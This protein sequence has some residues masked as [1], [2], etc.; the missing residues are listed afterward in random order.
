MGVIDVHR[1][2]PCIGFARFHEPHVGGSCDERYSAGLAPHWPESIL[3]VGGEL[4]EQPQNESPALRHLLE[5][6][7]FP[8]CD[9]D[10]Q[11]S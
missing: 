6:F 11:P 3:S 9:F 8:R 5:L 1:V 10:G 7:Q 2:E 4:S